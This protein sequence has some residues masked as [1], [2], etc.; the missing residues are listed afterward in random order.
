MPASGGASAPA[1]CPKSR[2]A[3]PVLR[4]PWPSRLALSLGSP[5]HAGEATGARRTSTSPN[6]R[7]EDVEPR[8]VTVPSASGRDDARQSRTPSASV[9]LGGAGRREH[10]LSV[11]LSMW[12]L[13]AELKG[14]K[15]QG[16]RGLQAHFSGGGASGALRAW[17]GGVEEAPGLARPPR[18]QAGPAL[19][20]PV[21]WA[22]CGVLKLTR[23]GVSWLTA[24]VAR[25]TPLGSRS[26]RGACG[27]DVPS[28]HDPR[29]AYSAVFWVAIV[30]RLPHGSCTLPRLSGSPS[31]VR[32]ASSA[33]AP[34]A[35]AA[36]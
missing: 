32:G 26:P 2:P 30:Q 35:S 12:P 21:T 18:R 8:G 34:A 16:Q 27:T 10:R 28:P 3:R 36:V 19:P 1:S 5:F 4:G 29:L 11:L 24:A 31:R 9:A 23:N 20:R 17:R 25:L 13:S 7:A 22:T 6:D 15:G 14:L 33:V